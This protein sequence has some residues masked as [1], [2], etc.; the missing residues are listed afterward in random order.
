MGLA[1]GAA[2]GN[3]IV[4]A[5]AMLADLEAF[6]VMKPR[7]LPYPLFLR[8]AERKARDGWMPRVWQDACPMCYGDDPYG[9]ASYCGEC[10][11]CCGC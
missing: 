4:A 3:R 6:R 9:Q 11:F 10:E 7:W 5:R 2:I 1:Q 8:T